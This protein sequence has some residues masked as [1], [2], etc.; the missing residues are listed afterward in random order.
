MVRCLIFTPLLL[1]ILISGMRHTVGLPIHVAAYLAIPVVAMGLGGICL[2]SWQRINSTSP[3]PE[4]LALLSALL[5]CAV[6]FFPEAYGFINTGNADGGNHIRQYLRYIS[7]SPREYTGFTAFYSLLYL[8]E[9]GLALQLETALLAALNYTIFTAFFAAF[10]WGYEQRAP[11]PCMAIVVGCVVLPVVH[12]L[13]SNGFYAQLLS[14]PVIVSYLGLTSLATT[15]LVSAVL[16]ASAA[17]ALRF[18]YGLNLPDL[19]LAGAISLFVH[20]RFVLALILSVAAIISLK[21]LSAVLPIQGIHREV[22]AWAIAAGVGCFALGAHRSRTFPY[23]LVLTSAATWLMFG[24]LYGFSMYYVSKHVLSWCVVL[25]VSAAT[26]WRS[27][28][29]LTR[30]WL[31][32][33][34]ILT[35]VG[36]GELEALTFQSLRARNGPPE[37]DRAL[38]HTLR[39]YLHDHNQTMGYFVSTKWARTNMTNAMF[40]RDLSYADYVNGTIEVRQGCLFLESSPRIIRQIRRN[41]F[42]LLADSV[43]RLSRQATDTLVIDAPWSRKKKSDVVVVCR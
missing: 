27:G 40:N 2:F 12:Y 19:L 37:V 11:V 23:V 20:K 22:F 43:E 38:V 42:P 7:T 8:L 18:S 36:L 5:T 9:H 17:V 6:I 10:L 29:R 33:G 15:P 28:N 21:A 41:H 35:C 16:F 24:A 1:S 31:C 26:A 30:T 25:A 4:L 34:V 32:A 3:R 39:T 13:Q 14:V